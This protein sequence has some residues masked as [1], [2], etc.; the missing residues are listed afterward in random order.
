MAEEIKLGRT[1]ELKD[2]QDEEAL[3][4]LRQR[5]IAEVNAALAALEARIEVLE[6]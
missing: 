5:I 3:D 1:L 2:A 6:A 4:E